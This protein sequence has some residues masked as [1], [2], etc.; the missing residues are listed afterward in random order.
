MKLLFINLLT[1]SI[2]LAST[3]QPISS[4]LTSKTKININPNSN[5]ENSIYEFN[6]EGFHLIP[7]KYQNSTMYLAKLQDGASILEQGSPDLHKFCIA[8][9]DAG[10]IQMPNNKRA[11]L[12]E[13]FSRI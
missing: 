6:I 13:T 1:F 4:N 8:Y 5:I 11:L 3:W 9:A 2:M 12:S 10:L 7:V